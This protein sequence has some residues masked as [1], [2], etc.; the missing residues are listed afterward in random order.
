MSVFRSLLLAAAFCSQVFL[1]SC[2]SI[3]DS[4]IRSN[5]TDYN[6]AI[7]DTSVDQLLLNIVRVSKAETPLFMDLTE[8]DASN[9]LQTTIAGGPSNVGS[10]TGLVGAI[11]GTASYSDAPITKYVPL[12]GYPLIQQVSLPVSLGSIAKLTNSNWPYSTLFYYSFQRLAPAYLDFYRALDTILALDSYGALS[13]DSPTE[14]ELVIRFQPDGNLGNP[15]SF[16]RVNAADASYRVLSCS[17]SANTRIVTRQLWSKLKDIYKPSTDDR[18]VLGTAASKVKHVAVSPR[19]ALGALKEAETDHILFVNRDMAE[20]IRHAND[21][22]PCHHGEFYYVPFPLGAI[23]EYRE[24]IGDLWKRHFN[25]VYSHNDSS[26]RSREEFRFLGERRVYIIVEK[27][28]QKPD[29]AYASIYKNGEWFSIA[30]SDRI[31]KQ[32]FALL[33]QILTIQASPLPTSGTTPTTIA[34]SR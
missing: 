1:A 19:S 11:T 24:K 25:A 2:V 3:G 14:N 30:D 27:S 16:S 8:V 26:D 34:I 21:S 12:T 28:S 20:E 9:T 22:D 7:H 18:I 23:E 29:D 15:E 33:G 17:L 6:E 31:S 13:F 32:N 4:A 10:P 5:R